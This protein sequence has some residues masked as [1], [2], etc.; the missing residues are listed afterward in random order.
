MAEKFSASNSQ[1]QDERLWASHQKGKIKLGQLCLKT[2]DIN[3]QCSARVATFNGTGVDVRHI[4]RSCWLY[5]Y[6][7]Y[8][9]IYLHTKKVTQW[10]SFSYDSNTN[11]LVKVHLSLERP[12]NLQ[13]N[14]LQIMLEAG[15]KF[16]ARTSNIICSFVMN[17]T[18]SHVL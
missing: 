10:K 17:E 8:P 15:N 3:K 16:L 2:A 13:L 12:Q 18:I 1:V 6:R 9:C 4:G 14:E 11:V 7:L 5:I